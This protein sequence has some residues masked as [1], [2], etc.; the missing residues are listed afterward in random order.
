MLRRENNYFLEHVGNSLFSYR[1]M[2]AKVEFVVDDVAVAPR[3]S[4]CHMPLVVGPPVVV[5]VEALVGRSLTAWVMYLLCLRWQLVGNHFLKF[6]SASL[7][8]SHGILPNF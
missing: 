7:L 6:Q 2:Q 8:K 1:N 5:V 3:R 4:P